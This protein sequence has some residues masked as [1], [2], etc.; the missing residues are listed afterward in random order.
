MPE[1]RGSS[2]SCSPFLFI[3][4]Y[5]C[6]WISPEFCKIALFESHWLDFGYC[7]FIRS[8][9]DPILRKI[10][11]QQENHLRLSVSQCRQTIVSLIQRR[12]ALTRTNRERASKCNCLRIALK[13]DGCLAVYAKRPVETTHCCVS[14][15]HVANNYNVC[16]QKAIV[17]G[18]FI[19][20]KPRQSLIL[21]LQSSE[22]ETEDHQQLMFAIF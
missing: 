22:R 21:L 7:E 11:S 9:F 2:Y 5:D 1:Y 4:T 6:H 12:T 13:H 15:L 14:V 3:N 16:L 19:C 17:S 18:Q 10:M 8:V 20:W